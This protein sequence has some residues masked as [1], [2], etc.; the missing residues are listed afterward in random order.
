MIPY[1]G[2]KK[3]IANELIKHIPPAD[4]FY[5]LFGGGGAITC[6]V[7]KIMKV[8]DMFHGTKWKH[9]HYNEINTG[10]YLLFREVLE[11][12]FDFEKAKE[13]WI[14]REE[15][16]RVKDEPTAWGAY[17][18]FCW[19]FGN[20]GDTYCYGKNIE[21]AKELIFCLLHVEN[22]Y[23]PHTTIKE[24]RLVL[25]QAIRQLTKKEL[26]L[27]SLE[28]LER[29]QSLQSLQITNLDYRDVPIQPLSVVYC[30][31]PYE[32]ESA[33]KDVYKNDFNRAAF[34][35]WAA[36][37]EFPVYVSE[38]EITDIRFSL[39]WEKEIIIKMSKKNSKGI[40]RRERLYWNKKE[41][42]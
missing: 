26:Y 25:A 14:S 4:H 32:G 19:S 36:T 35:D 18:R 17:V 27:Q 34:L 30:D 33:V 6:A 11:E 41:I 2:S 15:F 1:R 23:L 16:F 31:I 12:K 22:P 8:N 38:Y 20:D 7:S 3:A 10:V 9:L 40:Y 21:L 42:R 5:D 13:T 24:R 28:R 29:L 37:R 39:I